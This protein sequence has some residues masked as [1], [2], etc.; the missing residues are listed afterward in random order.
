MKRPTRPSNAAGPHRAL[1]S[2]TIQRDV[3]YPVR[4]LFKAAGLGSKSLKRAESEGLKVC[5]YGGRVFVYGG[6]LI[7]FLR[8]RKGARRSGGDGKAAAERLRRR[9]TRSEESEG[10]P[11]PSTTSGNGRGPTALP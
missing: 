2:G 6:D 8:G 5:R 11:S 9:R 4:A 3:L 10:N 7:R 1:P